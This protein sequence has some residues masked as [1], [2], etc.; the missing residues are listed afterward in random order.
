MVRTG[1]SAMASPDS[2]ERKASDVLRIVSHP[3]RMPSSP[4]WRIRVTL[5]PT[6][7]TSPRPYAVADTG[8]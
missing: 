7:S 2:V 5:A 8:C 3:L 4:C 1:I 6:T